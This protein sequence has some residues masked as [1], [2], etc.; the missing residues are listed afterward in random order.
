MTQ[1]YSITYVIFLIF[2]CTA[3]LSTLALYTRQSLLVAYIAL[4]MIFGPWGLKLV[5]NP[6]VIQKT[7]DIGIIFLLFLLGLDLQPQNLLHSLRKMSLITLISSLIFFGIGIVIG[8]LF[9]YT[10]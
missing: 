2:A 8:R 5:N 6:V 3:L 10:L 4:G 9:G 1:T 7:G